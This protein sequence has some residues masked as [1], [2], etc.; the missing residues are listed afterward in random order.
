MWGSHGG[1]GREWDPMGLRPDHSSSTIDFD[2]ERSSPRTSFDHSEIR[3]GNG[4]A[5]SVVENII[6]TN[7][8]LSFN[9]NHCEIKVELYTYDEVKTET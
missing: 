4:F 2:L 1:D 6:Y 8:Y 9:D 7:M 5:P 3:S